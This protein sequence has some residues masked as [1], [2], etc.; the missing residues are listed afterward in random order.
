MHYC[1]HGEILH[2]CDVGGIFDG[3]VRKLGDSRIEC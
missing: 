2:E 3:D 1:L